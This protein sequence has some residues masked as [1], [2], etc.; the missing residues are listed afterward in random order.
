MA[1]ALQ[2]ARSNLSEQSKSVAVPI[3]DTMA[4]RPQILHLAVT[5]ASGL[6]GGARDSSS[7]TSADFSRSL[8]REEAEELFRRLPLGES[9]FLEGCW[10]PR[11]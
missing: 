6:V 7:K 8:D 9:L 3:Q 11:P 2:G 5:S 1:Q 10:P 4:N